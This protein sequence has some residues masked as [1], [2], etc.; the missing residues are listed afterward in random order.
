MSL[1][2]DKT[3]ERGLE[4]CILCIFIFCYLPPRMEDYRNDLKQKL[5]EF[6]PVLVL[7]LVMPISVSVMSRRT[8]TIQ[9]RENSQCSTVTKPRFHLPDFNICSLSAL[10]SP[11]SQ[12]SRSA[13]G[14][15]QHGASRLPFLERRRPHRHLAPAQQI[16][17]FLV[18]Q[19]SSHAF[20]ANPRNSRPGC[21]I[22]A[23]LVAVQ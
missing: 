21:Q 10:L 4:L 14:K 16:W 15:I 20:R 13:A 23:E 6:H 12:V 3:S 11:F 2:G 1:I 19:T 18:C 22:W 8:Q 9:S 5:I 17:Y 7:I